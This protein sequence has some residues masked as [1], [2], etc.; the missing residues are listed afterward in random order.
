MLQLSFFGHGSSMVIV[1]YQR[2]GFIIVGVYHSALTVTP[3]RVSVEQYMN[4]WQCGLGSNPRRSGR[5]NFL[6]QGRL[7]VLTRISV[8]VPSPCY[9]SST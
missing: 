3:N 2:C 4:V 8:S 6:L 5:E 9:R 7:S 1:I